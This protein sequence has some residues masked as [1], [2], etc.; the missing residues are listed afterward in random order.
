MKVIRISQVIFLLLL[1]SCSFFFG[2][3]VDGGSFGNNNLEQRSVSL[4]AIKQKHVDGVFPSESKIEWIT[5]NTGVNS[6]VDT[7]LG[8]V[9]EDADRNICT[10][11]LIVQKEIE[12]SEIKESKRVVLNFPEEL[13]LDSSIFFNRDDYGSTNSN[14]ATINKRN[15]NLSLIHI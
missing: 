9:D 15:F 7:D 10:L 4:S 3:S 13:G 8:G 1:S 14:Y 11:D 12:F 6:I 2:S 5:V